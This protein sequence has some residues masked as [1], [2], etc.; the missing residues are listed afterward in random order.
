M[1]RISTTAVKSLSAAIR[2]SKSGDIIDISTI[3]FDPGAFE[4]KAS[5]NLL[6]IRK[7]NY[8]AKV[9]DDGRTHEICGVFN[10]RNG[11]DWHPLD[12]GI[13]TVNQEEGE[14]V[15]FPDEAMFDFP[16]VHTL[17]CDVSPLARYQ[18]KFYFES[19]GCVYEWNCDTSVIKT[20]VNFSS[21]DTTDGEPTLHITHDG[22]MFYITNKDVYNCDQR[23]H[24]VISWVEKPKNNFA[25]NSLGLLCN[26]LGSG[27][28]EVLKFVNFDGVTT[29]EY[30]I[31]S[32]SD[33]V[34]DLYAVGSR[35]V[36]INDV[37]VIHL[38]TINSKNRSGKKLKETIISVD[39]IELSHRI[40]HFCFAPRGMFYV[41]PDPQISTSGKLQYLRLY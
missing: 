6:Y 5:G 12:T 20:V 31:A 40:K 18:N 24:K 8:I 21:K 14:V 35:F 3:D 37:G 13:V 33:V 10:Q 29:L 25:I 38:I 11:E 27:E 30:G 7:D 34:G 32:R 1:K 22:K 2:A 16:F 28:T 41:L 23:N 36:R 9:A 39:E 19:N 4:L 17:R 26:A 15:F